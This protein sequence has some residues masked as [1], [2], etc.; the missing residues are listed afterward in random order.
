MERVARTVGRP[1]HELKALQLQGDGWV[2]VAGQTMEEC[3]IKTCWDAVYAK[4]DFDARTP[5]A[6]SRT[7]SP[8]GG[9]STAVEEGGRKPLS[10]QAGWAR[11]STW[12]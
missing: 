3:R 12:P 5:C 1:V 6:Q 11:R 10:D 7:L 8:G 9:A 2:T 4:S